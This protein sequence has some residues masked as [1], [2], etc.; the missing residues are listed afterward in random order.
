MKQFALIAFVLIAAPIQG[1]Q[2]PAQPPPTAPAATQAGNA[3]QGKKLFVSYG[4]YQCHGYEAQ[5]SSA[6]G[7]RLGPRPIAFA[8]FVKYVRQPTGQMPPYTMKVAS[9]SDLADIYAFVAARPTP[10]PLQSIPLL[11]S[12]ISAPR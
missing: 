7:P 9:D 2:E 4:C 5:G 10:P 6:T 11:T 1:G 8:G 3:E 12:E